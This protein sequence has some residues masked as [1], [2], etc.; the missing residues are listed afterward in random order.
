MG[1]WWSI[2][3][4]SRVA[5]ARPQATTSVLTV[6][7]GGWRWAASSMS[8]KP[9]TD[10]SPGTEMPRARASESPAVAIRSLAKT[11]AV[12]RSARSSSSPMA[13]APDSAEKSA[14]THGPS[15]RPAAASAALQAR[16]RERPWTRFWGPATCAMRVWPSS[17]R[18]R[19]T[20]RMPSASSCHTADC[21]REAAIGELRAD[22]HARQAELL[23]QRRALVVHP[24]V[25][26]EDAVDAG[27][28]GEPAVRDQVVVLGDLEQQRMS[29]GGERGLQARDERR[30][31]G[32][33]AEDLRGRATTRPTAWE[34]E[35]D[36]ARAR[37]L[38]VQPRS[39]AVARIRRRVSSEMPGRPLRANDTAPLETPAAVATSVIVG[40]P[41]PSTKPV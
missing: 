2:S 6:V 3:S 20:E 23:E 10:I 7:S 38:G 41:M 4:S 22:Q 33:D 8:S 31:E 5:A 29:T 30:E 9:V 15:G 1:G 27:L 19:T 21:G 11:T 35:S 17:T 32:V 40:R 37:A 14:S 18:W 12:G 26:E 16:R 25:R 39:S 13:R 36:S 34:R 28:L 24:E